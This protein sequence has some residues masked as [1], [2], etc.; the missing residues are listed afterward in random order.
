ME[1]SGGRG[2]QEGGSAPRCD[3][4]KCAGLDFILLNKLEGDFREVSDGDTILIV[5][6]LLCGERWS[7]LSKVLSQRTQDFT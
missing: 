2:E 6:S 1:E 5:S 7:F 4:P 3:E